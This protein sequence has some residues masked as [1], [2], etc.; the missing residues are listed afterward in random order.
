M[1]VGVEPIVSVNESV[2]SERVSAF[3]SEFEIQ[4]PDDVHRLYSET[5][6]FE[7]SWYG[8]VVIQFDDCEFDAS[9]GALRFPTIDELRLCRQRWLNGEMPNEEWTTHLQPSESVAVL[10]RMTKWLPF[11]DSDSGDLMCIDTK[12]GTIVEYD[13]EWEY[14]TNGI[15]YAGSLFEYIRRC[16]KLLFF[17]P[18]HVPFTKLDW[19]SILF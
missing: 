15:E 16:S 4:L 7:V 19:D 9:W 2:P 10:K 13:H 8:D 3:E 11:D 5:N 6:G 17:R 18:W 12:N 1:S 14:P